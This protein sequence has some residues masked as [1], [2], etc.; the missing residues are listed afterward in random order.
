MYPPSARSHGPTTF[1][2]ALAGVADVVLYAEPT[3]IEALLS[4]AITAKVQRV[5]LLS[6]DSAALPDAEH[7]ALARHHLRVQRC[8]VAL[9]H[10]TSVDEV[11]VYEADHLDLHTRTGWSVMVTGR[12][13]PVTAPLAVARYR[14]LLIRRPTERP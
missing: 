2:P 13:T 12:A 4:T 7:N 3:E 9:L 14:D 8:C 10:N 5:V 6:S 11:V 1:A